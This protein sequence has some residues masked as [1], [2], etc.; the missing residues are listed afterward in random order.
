[1]YNLWSILQTNGVSYYYLFSEF[2]FYVLNLKG[3]V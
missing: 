1:M 2:Q 3:L